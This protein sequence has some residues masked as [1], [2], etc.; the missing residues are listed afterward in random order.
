MPASQAVKR[1]PATAFSKAEDPLRRLRDHLIDMRAQLVA[2][3]EREFTGGDMA[4]LATV[5]NALAGVEAEITAK[6]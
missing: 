5:Q 2:R 4:L 6:G 3:L 1:E